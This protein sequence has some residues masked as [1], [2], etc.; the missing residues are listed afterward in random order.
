MDG[1]FVMDYL[2]GYRV[3]VPDTTIYLS[4]ENLLI[5]ICI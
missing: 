1:A 3:Q 4:L 2:V 5:Y